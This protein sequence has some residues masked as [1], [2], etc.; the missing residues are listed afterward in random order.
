MKKLITTLLFGVIPQLTFAAALQEFNKD[1]F[2]N[3][4]QREDL[5][6]LNSLNIIL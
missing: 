6:L 5:R 3:A 4:V 1:D 2:F